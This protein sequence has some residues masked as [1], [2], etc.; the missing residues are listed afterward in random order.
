MSGPPRL[1]DRARHRRRL[2]RAAARYSQASFLKLRAAEDLVARLETVKREFPLAADLGARDGTFAR[3]LGASGAAAKVGLLIE[4]DLSSAML[5]GRP[6]PRLVADEEQLP[7]APGS[8][9][10]VVS[11]LALHWT[12]DFVGALAQIRRALKPDGLFLGAMLGGSTLTELRQAL[13]IAELELRGG[14]GPRVSPFAD[15]S[16]AGSLLQR[17]GFAL[18]VADVDRVTVT[19]DH[20]LRLLADLRAMG[21]TSVLAEG[22]DRP[23]SRGIVGRAAEL[24]AERFAGPERRLVASFEIVTLTGWAPH[25]DQPKPLRPG[26]AEARLADALGVVEHKAGEKA[27]GS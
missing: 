1:F 13:S 12:N 2:D 19:Y 15:A 25:P 9:D 8:L 22:A 10:L 21:E 4:T 6:G 20:L 27:R 11:T 14:A 23:L 26:S 18:P 3:A 17:A 7:F 5:A 16:D 24:Y